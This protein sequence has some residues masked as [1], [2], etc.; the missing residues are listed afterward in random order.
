MDAQTPLIEEHIVNK[1]EGLLIKTLAKLG[2]RL[3]S[4]EKKMEEK[5]KH[6]GSAASSAT[7]GSWALPS[8]G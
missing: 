8:E 5:T 1:T 3:G 4:V 2:D 7:A 6:P